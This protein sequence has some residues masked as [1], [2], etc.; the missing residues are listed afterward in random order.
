VLRL[1]DL[2]SEPVHCEIQAL[3]LG[4][5]LIVA[6]PGEL[7]CQFGLD[8]KA[9]SPAPITFIAGYANGYVGYLPGRVDHALAA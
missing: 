2:G 9:A 5:A 3:R 7:F 4:E 1:I 8:L 6:V